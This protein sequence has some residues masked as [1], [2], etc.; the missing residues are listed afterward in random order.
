VLAA[1]PVLD[2]ISISDAEIIHIVSS[3]VGGALNKA[4]RQVQLDFNVD[5]TTDKL[6]AVREGLRGGIGCIKGAVTE[7][8]KFC[9]CREPGTSL[10]IA[11][12]HWVG[13]SAELIS[14]ELAKAVKSKAL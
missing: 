12:W 14:T 9:V 8:F 1:M 11:L 6:A 3:L 2:E 10:P 7:L 5:G 13:D 4:V